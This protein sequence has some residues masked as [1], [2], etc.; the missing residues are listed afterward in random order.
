[1]E[2][3]KSCDIFRRFAPAGR[4]IDPEKADQVVKDSV[5]FQVSEEVA[6]DL[7]NPKF[8]PFPCYINFPKGRK[9]VQLCQMVCAYAIM[10]GY[11]VLSS[12]C[13]LEVSV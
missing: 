4:L 2:T 13:I 10:H 7:T 9:Q 12:D 6:D 1:M 8:N 11:W 3:E 5:S